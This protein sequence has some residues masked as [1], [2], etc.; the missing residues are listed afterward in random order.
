MGL[1]SQDAHLGEIF[2]CGVGR[3][4]S[5][6][7]VRLVDCMDG[8]LDLVD[9]WWPPCPPFPR[10]DEA[11]DCQTGRRRRDVLR[12][13]SSEAYFPSLDVYVVE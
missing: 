6:W 2:A 4:P 9:V 5:L 8:L 3:F 10:E 11:F 12:G 7:V 1:V 13:K